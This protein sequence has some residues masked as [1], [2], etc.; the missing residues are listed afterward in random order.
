M[1]C[2]TC[3]IEPLPNSKTLSV[4]TVNFVWLLL[5]EWYPLGRL[6]ITLH[7]QH[8]AC[9][10]WAS[11]PFLRVQSHCR[12]LVILVCLPNSLWTV[13]STGNRPATWCQCLP[14]GSR[15][16]ACPNTRKYCY[17][18]DQAIAWPKIH[19][20]DIVVCIPAT[21]LWCGPHWHRCGA[22]GVSRWLNIYLACVMSWVHHGEGVGKIVRTR[23]LRHL[24]RGC[25]LYVILNE[26]LCALTYWNHIV[27]LYTHLRVF[28]SNFLSKLW[29]VKS[30]TVLC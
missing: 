26:Y 4:W 16:E 28:I 8:K 15:E 11:L 2:S 17:L 9:C 1:V 7:P 14:Q 21:A 19:Q 25:L 24:P 18:T 30:R 22:D 3:Y 13:W 10:L 23:G 5:S 29:F 12:G 6:L 27:A 20:K